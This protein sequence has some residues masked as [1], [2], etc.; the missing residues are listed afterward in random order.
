MRA[1][2]FL[3]VF[4]AIFFLAGCATVG[5]QGNLEMQGLRNQITALETQLQD[6]DSEIN[7]LRDALKKS[8]E[9]KVQ[10]KML[11]SVMK[12]L[13]KEMQKPIKKENYPKTNIRLMINGKEINLNENQSQN[14][15]NK[16]KKKILPN[17]F[18]QEN[19]KKLSSLPKQEIS[20]E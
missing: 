19:L 12:S 18:S 17:N 16:Q 1:V 15:K 5:K 8:E 11:G 20:L 6:K 2:K 4:S 13:E 3:V 9:T 10:N 7:V 14:N